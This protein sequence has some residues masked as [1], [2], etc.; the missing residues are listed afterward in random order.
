M[1]TG[2]NLKNKNKGTNN[3]K[4]NQ[5]NCQRIVLFPVPLCRSYDK[6]VDYLFR[7]NCVYAS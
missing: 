2:R 6:F 4:R 5:E 7:I 3:H 1:K